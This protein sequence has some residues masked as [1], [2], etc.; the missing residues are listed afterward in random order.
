MIFEARK[1]S[2]WTQLFWGITFYAIIIFG[3][4]RG[5][6]MHDHDWF[7]LF[8]LMGMAGVHG[9]YRE[10]FKRIGFRPKSLK[11]TFVENGERLLWLVLLILFLGLWFG[12][13][14]YTDSWRFVSNLGATLIWGLFQQYLLNGF[15]VNRLAGFF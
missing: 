5:Y 15:F 1:R 8:T 3:V 12:S 10:G 4:W 7:Y 13:V 14:R 9:F 11:V 6:D 2:E